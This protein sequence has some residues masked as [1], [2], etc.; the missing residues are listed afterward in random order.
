MGLLSAIKSVASKAVAAVKSVIAPSKPAPAPTPAKTSVAS[1]ISKAVSVVKSVVGTNVFP[2]AGISG[3]AAA[4]TLIE[5]PAKEI[6]R[7]V[8]VSAAVSAAAAPAVAVSIA[9]K[10]VPSSLLGKVGLGAIA[11][12]AVIAVVSH[13]STVTKAATGIVNVEGNL[14]KVAANP[15]VESVKELVTENPIIVG[16]AAAAAAIF[17]V[18]AA[19]PAITGLLTAE[20]VEEQTAAIREQTEVIK[21]VGAGTT[22]LVPE[23]AISTNEEKPVETQTT[24]IQTGK[25]KRRKAKAAQITPSMKQSLN[26]LINNRYSANRINKN[27]IKRELLYN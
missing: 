6:T 21:D 10:L 25:R 11:V 13:P 27:Y 5:Q 17:G 7:A 3:V 24:T 1:V 8:A 23:K 18:K 14:I 16:T 15:S 26:V 22:A 12:P 2:S 19:V 4:K 9:S 20:R